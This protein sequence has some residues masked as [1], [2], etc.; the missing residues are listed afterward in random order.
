MPAKR[1][2]LDE[3]PMCDVC[4][5]SS[6][7]AKYMDAFFEIGVLQGR[8][9]VCE[10]CFREVCSYCCEDIPEV[11]TSA[12]GKVYCSHGCMVKDAAMCNEVIQNA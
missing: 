7:D 11:A 10:K 8:L 9:I 2:E 12:N 6:L 1:I 5:E 4:Y 3:F